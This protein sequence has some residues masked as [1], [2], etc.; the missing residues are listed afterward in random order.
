M[1]LNCAQIR[2]YDVA[3]GPGIR[4][5]LF[6]S[7][8]NHRCR[9]CFNK[10]YQDFGYGTVWSSK[11]EDVFMEIV[12]LPNV[13]GVTILGGEPMEQIRDEDL[14]HLLVRIKEETGK[15]IWIYSGFTFDEIINNPK[16]LELLKL[17]DVLVDGP[18]VDSLKNPGLKF[19][20]SSNQ[21]IIDIDKSL[22]NNEPVIIG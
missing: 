15:S 20:G 18:F 8:C 3:N 6:V 5:T 2:R 9:N 12:K 13:T 11:V 17:C 19:K 22:L 7:G 4:T 14:K 21:N 16:R 1:D 10:Q